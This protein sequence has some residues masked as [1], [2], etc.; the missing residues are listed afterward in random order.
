MCARSLDHV[1]TLK[2]KLHR[3]WKGGFLWQP[4]K[5]SGSATEDGRLVIIDV[6]FNR[7][8][9]LPRAPKHHNAA[10]QFL[11]VKPIASQHNV[12]TYLGCHIGNPL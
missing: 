7:V 4:Q 3:C 8:F 10:F 12:S 6:V 1:E 11:Q 9:I 2:S 5:W